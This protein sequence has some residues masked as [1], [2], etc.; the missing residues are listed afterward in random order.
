MIDEHDGSD[1]KIKNENE[2]D[3]LYNPTDILEVPR[4]S[5]CFGCGK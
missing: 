2:D 3:N 1:D 5:S 4:L